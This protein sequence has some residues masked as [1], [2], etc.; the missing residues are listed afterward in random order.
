MATFEPNIDALL[1]KLDGTP[2]SLP[3]PLSHHGEQAAKRSKLF[4]LS[5]LWNSSALILLVAIVVGLVGSLQPSLFLKI[6]CVGFVPWM[7]SGHPLPPDMDETPLTAQYFHTYV[8]DS[9]RKEGG[10]HAP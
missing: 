9:R 8:T 3:P 2:P 1:A 5:F 4:A 7:L 6:P 10:R